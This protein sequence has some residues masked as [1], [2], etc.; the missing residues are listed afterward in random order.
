[1]FL[2]I[3][4]WAE[5]MHRLILLLKF[6]CHAGKSKHL[7]WSLLHGERSVKYNNKSF[8]IFNF[9]TAVMLEIFL[10]FGTYQ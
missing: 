4:V 1:M 5:A 9:K 7:D 8:V 10:R 3:H 2:A 6:I